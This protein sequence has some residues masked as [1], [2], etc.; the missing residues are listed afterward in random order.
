MP[1]WSLRRSKFSS[2]S[3]FCRVPDGTVNSKIREA[4]ALASAL[5]VDSLLCRLA[6][7]VASIMVCQLPQLSAA[8]PFCCKRWRPCP[9]VT[10]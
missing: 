9:L 3:A 4:S 5:A 8:W 7:L 2:A 6:L 10:A 1:K